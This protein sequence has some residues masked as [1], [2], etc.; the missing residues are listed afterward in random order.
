MA[1]NWCPA[2]WFYS[3]LDE[4]TF[5]MPN[6]NET[7]INKLQ[8]VPNFF[9][10]TFQNIHFTKNGTLTPYNHQTFLSMFWNFLTASQLISWKFAENPGVDS[11]TKLMLRWA[12]LSSKMVPVDGWV[13]RQDGVKPDWVENG[14]CSNN[15]SSKV[16]EV[17]PFGFSTWAEKCVPFFVSYA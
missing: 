16:S 12:Y 14:H 2:E 5:F 8:S 10:I 11:L 6:F 17:V 4:W 13:K 3:I 1:Q 15:L 9:Q 7:A